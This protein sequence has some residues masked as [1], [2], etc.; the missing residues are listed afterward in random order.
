MVFA[1]AMF[2]E[3]VNCLRRATRCPAALAPYK[4]TRPDNTIVT[5]YP[6]RNTENSN[7]ATLIYCEAF[8]AIQP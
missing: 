2:V 1:R 4:V 8:A 6:P 7:N 3:D 5:M